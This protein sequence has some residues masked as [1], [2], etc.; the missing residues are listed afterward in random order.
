MID[1]DFTEEEM[2]ALNYERFYHPD[3][4]VQRKMEA[5]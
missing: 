5:L 4:S 3:P 1:I 2:Q